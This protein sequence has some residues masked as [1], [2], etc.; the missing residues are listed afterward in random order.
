MLYKTCHN[1]L[2][3]TNPFVR[4]FNNKKRNV[5]HEIAVCRMTSSTPNNEFISDA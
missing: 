5:W 4:E 2:N 3:C 1:K